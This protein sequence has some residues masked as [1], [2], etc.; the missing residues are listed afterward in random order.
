MTFGVLFLDRFFV[1]FGFVFGGGRRQGRGLSK[2]S[3]SADSPHSSHHALL[4]LC[5]GAANLKASPLPPAP[6]Q[7]ATDDDWM[8]PEMGHFLYPK[9]S[10]WRPRDSI[11]VS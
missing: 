1:D 9:L 10:F 8:T 5:G 3:D 4:P 7:Q 2:S 11:L 6:C